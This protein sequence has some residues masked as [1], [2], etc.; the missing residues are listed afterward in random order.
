MH[1]T[2]VHLV[3]PNSIIVYYPDD[4]SHLGIFPISPGESLFVTH[5][6][7]PS[8]AKCPSG[9]FASHLNRLREGVE[10]LEL[11][12]ILFAAPLR[13]VP[14]V[15]DREPPPLRPGQVALSE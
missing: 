4:I 9:R 3:F 11:L 2:L 7:G 10:R 15:D 14:D 1:G 12:L 5:D 6:A 8:D 13:E